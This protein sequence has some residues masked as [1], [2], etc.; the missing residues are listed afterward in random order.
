M[1]ATKLRGWT[2]AHELGYYKQHCQ[3]PFD[4]QA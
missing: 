1:I 4:V 2:N 3:L